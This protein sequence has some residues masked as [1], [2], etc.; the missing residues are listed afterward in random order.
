MHLKLSI[1]KFLIK[2]SIFISLSAIFYVFYFTDVIHKY[3]D[4]Y[5]NVAIIK[6][7]LPN[8]MKPPYLTMCLSPHAKKSLLKH[9]NLSLGVFSEPT[10]NE[11]KILA[12][13]NITI[14]ELFRKYT[15][16]LNEDHYLYISFWSYEKEGWKENKTKLFLGQD[17]K[18]KVNV[19]IKVRS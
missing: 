6:E 3:A 2:S 12:E 8:G 17:N 14:E 16:K 7:T 9:K 18:I 15:F 4:G 13:L 10:V 1:I 19:L 11:Q 5:T